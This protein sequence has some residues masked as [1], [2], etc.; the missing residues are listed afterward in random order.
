MHNYVMAASINA[1][2]KGA[3]RVI[4]DVRSS[5]RFEIDLVNVREEGDDFVVEVL[6]DDTRVS[7]TLSA[8][9][10]DEAAVFVADGLQYEVET[11]SREPWP[12]CEGPPQHSLRPVLMRDSAQ[13]VCDDDD[14][15]VVIGGLGRAG[16]S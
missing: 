16:S 8:S 3:L 7:W 15:K 5:T 13:W 4:A 6:I 11:R 1:L 10:E 14:V 12:L 9:I 2:T